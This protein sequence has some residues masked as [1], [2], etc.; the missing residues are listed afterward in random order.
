MLFQRVFFPGTPSQWP[1]ITREAIIA[2]TGG[3][4][5]Q[6]YLNQLEKT[7]RDP[8]GNVKELP[9]FWTQMSRTWIEKQLREW[10]DIRYP[11]DGLPDDQVLSVNGRT[12]S[13]EDAFEVVRAGVY[14]QDMERALAEVVIRE[15]LR[16]E[17]VKSGHY[18]DDEEYS[19]RWDVY[20][21]PFDKTPFDT[22][23]IAVTFKGYPCLEAF[24]QRWRLIN[25]F[26]D[27]IADDI[28]DENLLA[29]GERFKALFSDGRISFDMI[30]FVGRNPA[31]RAWRPNGMEEA[32][33]RAEEAFELLEKGEITF[34]DL[35][36]QRGEFPPNNEDRGE[37]AY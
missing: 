22:R 24:R 15:A 20:R 37:L 9:A 7:M 11:S 5:G 30:P 14:A 10:S 12:W 16:Q 3:Q 23:L 21:E 31:T 4:G 28:T 13:A 17:L 35:K 32:R 27:M 33:K 26:Q 25:S 6:D 36:E 18:M 29:H 8:D 34:E 1:L 19:T 2:S